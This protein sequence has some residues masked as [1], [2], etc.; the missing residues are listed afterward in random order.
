MSLACVSV[1][2]VVVVVLVANNIPPAW[3]TWPVR[4]ELRL[5]AEGGETTVGGGLEAV[6]TFVTV[7]GFVSV[8][9]S[10]LSLCFSAASFSYFWVAA[11]IASSSFCLFLS[12]LE[13]VG[14]LSSVC[15]GRR[16][17]CVKSGGVKVRD[18]GA[19]PRISFDALTLSTS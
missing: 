1:A 13:R 19:N 3:P 12:A 8:L 4:R 6:P 15:P 11:A 16:T 2:I 5:R 17:M 14:I 9:C 10:S 7:D 18:Q